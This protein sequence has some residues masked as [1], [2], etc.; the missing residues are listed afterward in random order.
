MSAKKDE[1]TRKGKKTRPGR[2]VTPFDID[3]EGNVGE[4]DVTSKSSYKLRHY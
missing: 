4:R 3:F 2:D 1:E